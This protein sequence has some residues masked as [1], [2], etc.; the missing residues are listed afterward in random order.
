VQ[1]EFVSLS[2]SRK[3]FLTPPVSGTGCEARKTKAIQE[4][5]FSETFYRVVQKSDETDT[6]VCA[7]LSDFKREGVWGVFCNKAEC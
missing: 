2:Y 5:C 6:D 4:M 7:V 1:A 3:M